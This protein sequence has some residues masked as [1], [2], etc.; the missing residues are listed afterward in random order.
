MAVLS[1]GIEGLLFLPSDFSFFCLLLTTLFWVFVH[2]KLSLNLPYYF[3]P[4]SAWEVHCSKIA[5]Y[6]KQQRE[7]A[8]QE[9]GA[10]LGVAHPSSAAAAEPRHE[11]SAFPPEAAAAAAAAARSPRVLRVYFV[12]SRANAT[13]FLHAVL[14]CPMAMAVLYATMK[15]AS[16]EQGAPSEGP[17]WGAS[18]DHG[19]LGGAL[20]WLLWDWAESDAFFNTRSFLLD[21]I[22]NSKP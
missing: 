17:L 1:E 14:V 10:P 11:A 20:K 3:L 5:L 15:K 13:A 8:E 18:P 7:K 12:T 4:T 22:G 6:R 19:T 16:E 2:Q 9:E 21:V